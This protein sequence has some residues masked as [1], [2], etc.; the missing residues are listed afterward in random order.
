MLLSQSDKGENM[1]LIIPKDNKVDSVV[2]ILAQDLIGEISA[3]SNINGLPENFVVIP[4]TY[5]VEAKQKPTIENIFKTIGDNNLITSLKTYFIEKISLGMVDNNFDYL[6]KLESAFQ[7]INV[8]GVEVVVM[9]ENETKYEYNVIVR[10]GT[11]QT[12]EITIKETPK[13][14]HSSAHKFIDVVDKGLQI[15]KMDIEL[16]ELNKKQKKSKSLIN[17]VT[18]KKHKQ[19]VHIEEEHEINL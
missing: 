8:E 7:N 16:L 11:I 6:T 4:K 19:P 13:E 10:D 5:F 17:A 9:P 2:L 15:V 3:F 1:T 18:A 14:V 12:F